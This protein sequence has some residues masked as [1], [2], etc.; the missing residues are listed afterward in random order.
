MRKIVPADCLWPLIR[1]GIANA[2]FGAE[3]LSPSWEAPW[4]V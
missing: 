2:N 1:R 3:T 4:A